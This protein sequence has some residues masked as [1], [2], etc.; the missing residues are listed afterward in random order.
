MVSVMAQVKRMREFPP[1]MSTENH[2]LVDS[3]NAWL[4]AM[5]LTFLSATKKPMFWV[6]GRNA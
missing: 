5:Y 4:V 2:A 6:V 3:E 1:Q